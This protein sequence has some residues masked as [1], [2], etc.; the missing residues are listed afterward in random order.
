MKIEYLT[1]FLALLAVTH[2]EAT[3]TNSTLVEIS[4]SALEVLL[5]PFEQ[6]ILYFHNHTL[7]AELEPAL[8][9]LSEAQTAIKVKYPLDHILFGYVNRTNDFKD[10]LSRFGSENG[11]F[12]V[13]SL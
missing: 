7:P 2:S 3:L 10:S 13:N 1:L 9:T 5:Q 11:F 4:P 12:I 8:L 6:L